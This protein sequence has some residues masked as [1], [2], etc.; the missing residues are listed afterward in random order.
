MKPKMIL[1]GLGILA[2]LMIAVAGGFSHR[3]TQARRVEE[4]RRVFHVAGEVRSVDAS[5]YTVRIAHEEIPGYM[6]P[7]VMPFEV[8]QPE[9]LR[10]LAAGDHVVFELVITENDS[11]ILGIEKIASNVTNATGTVAG[12]RSSGERESERVQTGEL[13]PE[14]N[15]T[16]ENGRTIR[17]S[18]YR[19]QVLVLTFI[20]TRCPLPN[21]CPLMSKNFESLQDRLNRE[22]PD[23]FHLLSISIDPR[24]DQPEVLKEYAAR[25]GANQKCWTFATGTE[26]Q[27]DS[28]ADLM[29]LFHEPENGLIS[30]DLRTVLIGPDGRLVHMWRGNTWTPYEVQRMVGE[31]LREVQSYAAKR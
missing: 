6:P 13:V 9:L 22:F 30:H 11:W 10:D 23:R 14:F 4:N 20:Y 21:F 18:D 15:L 2:L 27:I 24:F 29:G 3:I 5:T 17:L 7:M 28:V 25:H 31:T 8:K 19:G 12:A 1:S 16:D 26:E